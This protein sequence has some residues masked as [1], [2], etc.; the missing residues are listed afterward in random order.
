MSRSRSG[1]NSLT[2][3]LPPMAILPNR[4]SAVACPGGHFPRLSSNS[5]RLGRVRSLA[6]SGAKKKAKKLLLWV[7][8][9]WR[10]S[11]HRPLA[12]LAGQ[13]TRHSTSVLS[14][15]EEGTFLHFR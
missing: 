7:L 3:T 5:R 15:D 12:A 14:S 8:S 4:A 11:D 10:F 2:A 9:F 13:Q 6:L 1:S